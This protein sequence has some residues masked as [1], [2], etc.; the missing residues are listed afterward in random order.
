MLA[1]RLALAAAS[2]SPLTALLT[3]APA[4]IAAPKVVADIPAIHSIASA[5]MTGVGEPRL[6]VAPGASPHGYAMKPSEAQAV[7]DADVIFWVG[8][9][10]TPWLETAIDTLGANAASH[11]MMDAP[12]LRL[13]AFRESS[14]FETHDHGDHEGHDEDHHEEHGEDHGDDGHDA[15]DDDH[16]KKDEDHTGEGHDDGVHAHEGDDDEGHE[17]GA[18]D[19]DPHIWLDPANGRAMADAIAAALSET[20]PTN[21]AA[22]AANAE[23]LKA[24]IDAV[25]ADLSAALA[26]VRGRPFIVFHDAYHYFEARFDVEATGALS[27]SDAATPGPARIEEIHALIKSAQVACVFTEPQFDQR[28]VQRLIEGVGAKSGQLDPQGVDIEPGP[29]HYPALL[30]DLGADLIACLS[31]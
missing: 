23:A 30:R 16:A 3:A 29:H 20:D 10:L 2:L 22:Y 1:T 21:A 11:E 7:A 27:V 28:L 24:E 14:T 15:H 25:E 8:R 17:H 4:A 31:S 9:E 5:V 6:I 26:A 19:K 12:G 18:D 13:L